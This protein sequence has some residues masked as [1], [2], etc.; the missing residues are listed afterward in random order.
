[1]KQILVILMLCVAVNCKVQLP[2]V[3][4]TAKDISE[5]PETKTRLEANFPPILAQSDASDKSPFIVGGRRANMGEIPHQVVLI[6]VEG[7]Y[8]YICGGSLINSK[9][10]LTVKY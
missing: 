6:I 7:P 9:W 3:F 5:R 10:V 8:A 1:M 2:E 4:R